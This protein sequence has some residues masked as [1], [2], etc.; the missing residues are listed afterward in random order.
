MMKKHSGYG[1]AHRV[2][3]LKK[4]SVNGKWNLFPAVVEPNGTLKNKVRIKGQIEV[5]PEG[6][7]YIEW[8]QGG[9]RKREAIPDRAQVLDSARRKA[10]ALEAAKIASQVG[11]I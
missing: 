1:P 6:A 11:Q 9:Q 2:N 8:W 10:I 5:H 7:Y 4:V 3:I